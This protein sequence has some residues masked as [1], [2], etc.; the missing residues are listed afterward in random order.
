VAAL[1]R[2]AGT[3]STFACRHLR[4]V[5]ATYDGF[6]IEHSEVVAAPINDRSEPLDAFLFALCTEND[7][8]D[9]IIGRRPG[10]RH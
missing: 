5:D 4:F 6:V 9:G 3:T 8:H 2:L 1:A 7:C 10:T